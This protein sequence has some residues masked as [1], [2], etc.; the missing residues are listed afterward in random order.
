M[1]RINIC[2]NISSF[3]IISFIFVILLN[4][5]K[6]DSLQISPLSKT[7]ESTLLP[8]GWI[9][10]TEPHNPAHVPAHVT[11]SVL[12]TCAARGTHL[13][14]SHAASHPAPSQVGIPDQLCWNRLP[15]RRGACRSLW[16]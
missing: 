9:Q 6:P 15:G 7:G 10:L 5:H 11:F 13:G 4:S 2:I 8:V 14:W 12:R 3:F 1:Y 16:A